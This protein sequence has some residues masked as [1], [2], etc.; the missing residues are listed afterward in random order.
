MANDIITAIKYIRENSKDL[1][2][3]PEK[4]CLYGSSGGGYA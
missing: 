4:I 3:D 2:I 1:N